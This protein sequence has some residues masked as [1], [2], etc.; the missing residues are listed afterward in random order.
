LKAIA[1]LRKVWNAVPDFQPVLQAALSWREP[2]ELMM[3]AP[4]EKLRPE[5]PRPG[6]AVIRAAS[7]L[8]PDSGAWAIFMRE[9]VALPHEM[10]PAVSQVIR[11]ERWKSAPDPVEAI[12]ADALEAYRRAWA[13]SKI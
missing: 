5:M 12:R 1:G 9:I 7:A 2:H 3:S 4:A 8:H 6:Y 13:K 10:T 11:L